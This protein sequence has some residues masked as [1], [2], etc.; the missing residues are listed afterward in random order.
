MGSKI[1]STN[2]LK[3]K[4]QIEPDA[5]FQDTEKYKD[6][7][8]QTVAHN[9]EKLTSEDPEERQKIAAAE[10]A[11]EKRTEAA[12]EKAQRDR[13]AR[14]EVKRRNKALQDKNKPHQQSGAW[15]KQSRRPESECG[16]E[17][18]EP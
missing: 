18:V 1:I 11:M 4:Q 16:T 13:E 14:L 2:D 17:R 7:N 3:S 12:R 5:L 6:F 9:I 10:I 8:D 15:T